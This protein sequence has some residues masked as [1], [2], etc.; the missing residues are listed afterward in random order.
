MWAGADV[1]GAVGR[2]E[3]AERR[4]AAA[5]TNGATTAEPVP[6][7]PDHVENLADEIT[8]L[9]AHI[10]AATHRLLTLIAEFDRLRGWDREG[11]RSCAHWLAFRTGIDL[12]AARE[13]VRVAR[14]LEGLPETS[15]AM[16]RGFL[17]FAKVRALTRVARADNE[18][19]LLEL[20]QGSTAA[21]LERMVR[22][23]RLLD[24]R[25]ERDLESKRHATRALS[26]FPGDDGMYVVRGRVDPEVGALLMRAVDAAS[27]VLYRRERGAVAASEDSAARMWP[28]T[29][30]S[31]PEPTPEQ[32]RADALGLLA[33][34]ALE[35]GFGGATAEGGEVTPLSGSRAARYQVV[36]HVEAA[37]LDSER[38]PGRSELEDGTRVSAETCRRMACDASV[39][40][41]RHGPDGSVLDVGRRTR[42]VPPAI[43]RALEARDHG[44]R[45]PGCGSRFTDAHHVM[46]WAD[47]GG[48]KL[49]NLVL[50]CRVH[51]RLVHEEGWRVELNPWP[52]GRPVFYDARGL[53]VPEAPP[54]REISSAGATE[55][56][57]R[58]NRQRGV[59]PS[60]D[61]PSCRWRSP[62]EIP[63][64]LL[65]RAEE[66]A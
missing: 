53:P 54:V 8:T 2:G 26:I 3:Q 30:P 38:E 27:D 13:K 37:T 34:R 63:L 56:L 58:A 24:R 4:A 1:A 39:V 45:F 29:A 19:D 47:G 11:H 46:H 9:A 61:T 51:H 15:A 16:E 50:L 59:D 21:E 40:Q 65:L 25:D 7:D 14:A 60:W 6:L 10:H 28:V 36:L 22:G 5:G 20:A 32:R 55:V 48:T 49:D 66:A 42:T 12:G 23:W 33:E 64:A 44:C 62:D 52:G 17:S 31:R 18:G 57:V 41:V 35:A 43:R